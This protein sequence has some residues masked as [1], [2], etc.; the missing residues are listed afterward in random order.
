MKIF[1]FSQPTLGMK[2]PEYEN[3]LV[4]YQNYQYFLPTNKE[5]D[6]YKEIKEMYENSPLHS[7]ILNNLMQAVNGTGLIAGVPVDDKIIEAF[8]LND[9]LEKCIFDFILF[10]GAY[11]EIFWNIEHTKILKLKHIKYSQIR[12]GDYDQIINNDEISVYL[13]CTD[14]NKYRDKKIV[15]L[16]PFNTNPNSDAHQ[17]M[18]ILYQN[19][20]DVY[21]KPYYHA[22]WRWIAI[23]VELSKFYLNLIKN[24]FISNTMISLPGFIEPEQKEDLEY[25]LK[26]NFTG[27]EGMKTIIF[28]PETP[29]MKPEIIKFNGED[30]GTKYHEWITIVSQEIISGHNLPS[31]ALA[32]IAQPGQLG[33]TQELATA[34]SIYNHKKVYPFRNYFLDTFTELNKWLIQ[35]LSQIEIEDIALEFI[36][37]PVAP[38]AT[39]NNIPTNG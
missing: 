2:F 13:Q 4:S 10:G 28:N 17:V 6:V 23:D 14:W 8:D 32:G 33:N 38:N 20:L 35:P 29:E 7:S 5:R 3:K 31:P 26:K 15:P 39:Q 37:K 22:L 16:V 18:P 36:E 24:N 19:F 12:I 1:N 30:D 21:P 11:I 27:S 25:I 9:I 34:N